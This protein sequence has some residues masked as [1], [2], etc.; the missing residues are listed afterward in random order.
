MSGN[1]LHLAWLEDVPSVRR[2]GTPRSTT[3]AA[4]N[5]SPCLGGYSASAAVS[6]ENVG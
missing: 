4:L 6:R 3:K 5:N 2:V 1:P